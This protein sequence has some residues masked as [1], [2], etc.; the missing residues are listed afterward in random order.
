MKFNKKAQNVIP[1]L[2]GVVLII[3]IFSFSSVDNRG[4]KITGAVAGMESVSGDMVGIT[5]MGA[6]EWEK[7]TEVI[8]DPDSL[9]SPSEIEKVY[10]QI[11]KNKGLVRV[12]EYDPK[13]ERP[14]QRDS[15]GLKDETK[16][17]EAVKEII[18]DLKNKKGETI[19]LNYLGKIK[20]YLE[21]GGWNKETRF[22]EEGEDNYNY[23]FPED[24]G[25]GEVFKEKKFWLL[26]D[27]EYKIGDLS[28]LGVDSDGF[29]LVS[30]TDTNPDIG[31]NRDHQ[32]SDSSYI[33]Y[34]DA[35]DNGQ[36][37]KGEQIVGY[38]GSPSSIAYQAYTEFQTLINTQP[39][40]TEPGV[41]K[42]QSSISLENMEKENLE[43]LIKSNQIKKYEPYFGDD[44]IINPTNLEVY[45]LDDQGNVNKLI[46]GKERT[47]KLIDEGYAQ[48]VVPSVLDSRYKVVGN[49]YADGKRY[50][51]IGDRVHEIMETGD[52]S[53]DSVSPSADNYAQLQMDSRIWIEEGTYDQVKIVKDKEGTYYQV[54]SKGGYEKLK[55]GSSLWMK[56]KLN[57]KGYKETSSGNVVDMRTGTPYEYDKSTGERGKELDKN[58]YLQDMYEADY[59]EKGSTG[60]WYESGG[61]DYVFDP[62]TGYAYY[63]S[64]DSSGG[65][66]TV[67]Q[68]IDDGKLDTE[69]KF[70][71]DYYRE[72]T[73][74][75]ETYVAYKGEDGTTNFFLYD[76]KG[77]TVDKTTPIN[78]DE[79]TNLRKEVK[80]LE[81]KE[82]RKEQFIQDK[83]QQAMRRLLNHYLGKWAYNQLYEMC[84]DEVESS[85]PS[86]STPVNVNPGPTNPASQ[87]SIQQSLQNKSPNCAGSSE[88]TLTAQGTKTNEASKF[89]YDI[90]WTI[91]PCKENISFDVY[92]ANT[93]TDRELILSDKAEKG[94]P[95]AVR[96]KFS[97]DKDYKDVCIKVSDNSIGNKGYVCFPLVSVGGSATN[98]NNGPN[99]GNKIIEADEQCDDGNS[100]EDDFCKNDCKY[101]LDIEITLGQNNPLGGVSYIDWEFENDFERLD[102]D[103]N[104]LKIDTSQNFYLQFYESNIGTDHFY[105][106]IQNR[107]NENDQMLIFSRW[108][109]RDLSNIEINADE[110]GFSESAGYEGDFVSVRLPN[111][112]LKNREYIFS[113]I[114]DKED[115]AGTW[116]KYIVTEK[117]TGTQKWGGSIRF[118]KGA[119]INKKGGTWTELF[120]VM[121]PEQTFKYLP[122]WDFEIK[123]IKG[124]G[125]EAL[126]AT[127]SY[128]E[129]SKGDNIPMEDISY[130]SSDNSF[131]VQLGP[132]VVRRNSAGVLV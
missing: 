123:S 106:G 24:S 107:V 20:G 38:V 31:T 132:D 98:I 53:K 91:L 103:V 100:N 54:S 70:K 37:D 62:H 50:V 8:V 13:A 119:K 15:P 122:S 76:K 92:T 74:G 95:K 72:V 59:F 125:K 12:G 110:N 105:F 41:T 117:S 66:P 71:E 51:R 68:K 81:I 118:D 111:F 36:I 80:S 39:S 10:N 86:S 61:T 23:Y 55:E 14:A 126:H 120:A 49:T 88:T 89:S 114:K 25:G 9:P 121:E 48:P 34:V 67:G 73:L 129:H 40:G 75:G 58:S 69:I 57:N 60:K 96:K 46:T 128:S 83:A 3:V 93:E 1:I 79:L 18:G 127:S 116:Y 112:N 44:Y 65:K 78:Q 90:S 11:L 2:L 102:I 87:N 7:S 124:D 21:E 77:G 6:G 94:K 35:N 131:R 42:T 56:N 97:K 32:F 27:T 99:C 115:A 22:K 4:N 30:W 82:Q 28:S 33:T 113:I 16:Y 52:I 26:P 64:K 19:P 17:Y 84:K 5:G 43:K 29:Q 109:T 63:L 130:D 108:G 101:N 85:E 45:S 104:F 47:S